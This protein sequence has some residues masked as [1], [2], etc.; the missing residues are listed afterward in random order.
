MTET[1]K[2][3]ELLA[4]S[5][6]WDAH[7][8]FM[9]DPAV[10]LA[11]LSIWR[12][13]GVDF[14]SI[15]VGFDLMPWEASIRTLAAFRHWVRRNSEH[16]LLADRF[17]DIA[18]ARATSRMAIAFDLEGMNALDGRIEMIALYRDLGVRQML[19]AYN[20][21]NVAGGGCHDDDCGLSEF[22]RR[23]IAEMNRVGITVD[24]S[25]AGYRTSMEAI[26]A[27]TRP[28]VFSH[29]NPRAVQ[30]HGRNI[31]DE[32][33]RACAASG[34]VVGAVGVSLFVGG[35]TPD[36]N[37][38]AD[39]ID[40]LIQIAGPRHVGLGL[41]FGF[42]VDVADVDQLVADNPEF[43]PPDE[44]YHDGPITYISPA[45]IR[46]LVEVMLRRGHGDEVVSGVLGANFA[47]VARNNW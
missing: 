40:H 46:D 17:E 33:I 4:N 35:E 21:N 45:R 13:A 23:A 31:V 12:D 30:R 38:M 32:Q 2:A 15:N 19:F 47:R 34:G 14:L 16:Y 9:P 5:L 26:E 1:A 6:V 11:N 24:V 36:A 37:R 28:V 27:S 39:H 44:G 3:T 20:R 8:G 7:S 10:D 22:G 42:P 18:L 41:D 29:S 43:W 25:H